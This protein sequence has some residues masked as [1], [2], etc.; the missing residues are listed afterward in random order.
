MEV[1]PQLEDAMDIR[2]LAEEFAELC[3]A[4]RGEEAAA[5]YWADDIRTY[6]AVPGE[7]AET[8]G[9]DQALEKAR[10]WAENH[11]VHEI[12]VE[13]PFVNGNQFLLYWEIEVTP[14]GGEREDIEEMV[15]YTVEEGRI[16]EE[17]YFY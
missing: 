4:G 1:S 2:D 3:A 9:K 16:V 7:Y 10:W 11:E 12:E 15:L 14:K 6:E 8:H 13:G 5:R 17:R